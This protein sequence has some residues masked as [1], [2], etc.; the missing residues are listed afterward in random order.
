MSQH[1][2]NEFRLGYGSHTLVGDRLT[3]ARVEAVALILHGGG[4][5]TGEG[6]QALRS[7]L[8][9]RHI[10]SISF[11]F[12]GHGRTGGSQQG[13]TLLQRVEQVQRVVQAMEVDVARLSLLGFSM[14]A[15]VATL[16]QAALR[17]PRL[18]LAIPAAYTPA[19]F[20]V[21]FGPAFRQLLRQPRS[22][23]GSD[24]FDRVQDFDGHLLVLSAEHDEVVPAEIPACY[25]ARAERAR[26]RVHHVIRGA[27][28]RLGP[29]YDAH[30]AA[31]R[32]AYEA[33]AALCLRP[34]EGP[35]PPHHDPSAGDAMPTIRTYNNATDREGVK[36]LWRTVFGYETAHN[37]PGLAI[38]KKLA[39]GDGM[40]LVAAQG[41]AI[42]GSVMA[43]Y[44][45]H[46]GWLYAVAVHP[47]Q[48]RRG[49]GSRLVAAAEAALVQVG[50]MKI[51]LQ[52]LDTNHATAAFYESLGYRVE[53][54]ISMGKL[55]SVNV[56]GA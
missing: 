39:V 37:E 34:L 24:A 12:V 47:S 7:F 2:C 15:Y 17:V 46:R 20:D 41:E 18:G 51:N 27:G 11:D 10:E 21:P 44:D 40:L 26:S 8:Y 19:A 38:D 36:A 55:L 28:H 53:P 22:W 50:C 6:F 56:P 35:S 29:H 9:D 31:Q 54:R 25:H 30:P 48:Q 42:V 33:I 13:T 52:L 45:G 3:P 49:L 23:E 1:L 43:G 4:T 16:A 5:S 32:Q 14:G